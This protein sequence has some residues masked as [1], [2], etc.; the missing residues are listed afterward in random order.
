MGLIPTELL[1]NFTEHLTVKNVS[2]RG[3]YEQTGITK[4]LSTHTSWHEVNR[5]R[6]CSPSSHHTLQTWWPFPLLIPAYEVK[7]LNRKLQQVREK[8]KSASRQDDSLIQ[9]NLSLTCCEGYKAV[10][11]T[12]SL[13]KPI[14]SVVASH[15]TMY[16]PHSHM[17]LLKSIWRCVFVYRFLCFHYKIYQIETRI[18]YGLK[19]PML[20]F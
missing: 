12:I 7:C 4:Q 1:F 2:A 19:F 14:Q 10:V 8:S 15:F 20:C 17:P 16:K 11:I 13:C 6:A 9:P 3:I 5:W 18:K